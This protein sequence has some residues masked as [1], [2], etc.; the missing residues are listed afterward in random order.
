MVGERML[1][2]CGGGFGM[3]RVQVRRF[4]TERKEERR[5]EI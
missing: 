3:G 1:V 4:Y 2:G 5:R